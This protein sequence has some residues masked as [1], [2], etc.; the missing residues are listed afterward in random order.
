M[1]NTTA[2]ERPTAEELLL[3]SWFSTDAN[4][5]SSNALAMKSHAESIAEQKRLFKEKILGK[6]AV[7]KKSKNTICLNLPQQ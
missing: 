7:E 5:K 4:Q 2:D 1:L 3:D 6:A